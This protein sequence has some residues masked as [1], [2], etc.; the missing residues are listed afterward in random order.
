MLVEIIGL[1][2]WH[3]GRQVDEKVRGLYEPNKL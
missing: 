3:A 1:A 2:G